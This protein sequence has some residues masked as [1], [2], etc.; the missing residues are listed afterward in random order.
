M[1]IFKEKVLFITIFLPII[2]IFLAVEILCTKEYLLISKGKYIEHESITF[3]YDYVADRMMGYLNYRYKEMDLIY[4]DE[5]I[6]VKELEERHMKDVLNLFTA[7]RIVSA[8]GII[9]T[10]INVIC[11]KKNNPK[12]LYKAVKNVWIWPSCLILF[13][14]TFAIIDFNL[15]FTIFHRIFFSNNDWL[16]PMESMIIQVVPENFWLVSA[17]LILLFLALASLISFFLGRHKLKKEYN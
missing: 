7:L 13:V 6:E 5:L 10:L 15:L 2:F 4:D 11:L 8:I 16:F 3:D 12:L 17:L 9:L 1:K 14:G